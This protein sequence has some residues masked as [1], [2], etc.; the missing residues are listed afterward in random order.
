MTITIPAS[1]LQATCVALPFAHPAY[2]SLVGAGSMKRDQST[3][4]RFYASLGIDPG[5]VVRVDQIHTRSVLVVDDSGTAT[6][7]C[8]WVAGEGDGLVCGA[9]GAWL[10]IGVGDCIPIYLAD[11]RTGAYGLLHSGWR[12]TGILEAGVRAM[13]RAFD[14]RPADIA[15]LLGPGIQASD[16]AVDAERARA[17]GRW[18]ERAV[19]KREGI[20]YLDLF[21]ANSDLGERLGVHSVVAVTNS[22]Y[23]TEQF[24]SYR[25]QGGAGYT[26]MLAL[27]G[28]RVGS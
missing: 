8:D 11:L 3:R 7:S 19:V 2:L 26:G 13:V 4:E 28:P 17:F 20:H 23:A 25:R 15:V 14:S 10:A 6:R 9:G 18:G 12:G 21:A 22:T 16:Y 24:G 27:I 5:T 1:E